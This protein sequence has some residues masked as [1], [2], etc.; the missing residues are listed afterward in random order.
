[1]PAPQFCSEGTL[2]Y[3]SR[4]RKKRPDTGN[5]NGKI[6]PL[7]TAPSRLPRGRAVS[8]SIANKIKR[9]TAGRPNAAT[10]VKSA[11]NKR[12]KKRVRRDYV[13]LC[14]GKKSRR[15]EVEHGMRNGSFVIKFN[16]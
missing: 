11:L 15:Y 4:V 5:I 6:K 9:S 7:E 8:H 3:L 10:G 14:Q 12:K 13:G 2:I 1:M 16:E